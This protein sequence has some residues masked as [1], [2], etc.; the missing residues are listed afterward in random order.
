M[1]IRTAV[2]DDVG[3]LADLLG[4]FA[5]CDQPEGAAFAPDLLRWWA[6]HD[7]H[8]AF[9]AVLPSGEAVGMA[10]LALTA[11][12]P[13]PAGAARLSG[14]VQSVFVV[15]EHR[16]AGVGS[17][18]LRAVMEHANQRALSLDE[19]A[20]FTSSPELLMWTWRQ[21]QACVAVGGGGGI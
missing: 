4:R 17:A 12:V 11:R 13:R 15:P 8:V 14:D 9:L 16:S 19:R 6:D 1:E 5:G 3:R 18:L 10:W 21:A 7:S 20:G 2:P